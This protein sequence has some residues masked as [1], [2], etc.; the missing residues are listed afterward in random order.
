MPNSIKALRALCRTDGSVQKGARNH[1]KA[2]VFKM[3]VYVRINSNKP[4]Q[5]KIY[6]VKNA[7]IQVHM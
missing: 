6:G 2:A 3:S 4:K 5:L 1:T 7:G